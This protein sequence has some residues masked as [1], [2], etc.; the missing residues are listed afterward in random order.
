MN[1]NERAS[2]QFEPV[3]WGV[4]KVEIYPAFNARYYSLYIQGLISLL[5]SSRLEYT[6]RDFPPFGA[7]CLAFR[8]KGDVERKIYLHSNDM[9]ELDEEG[10]RWCDLFG[11]VNLDPELVPE[12]MRSKVLALGP[13]MAVRVWNRYGSYLMA[14]R[15]L[16][17][18]RRILGDSWRQHIAN[19]R[20][21]YSS[22]FP[23]DAY[24]P[25][26]PRPNY[27]FYNAA[28]WEREPK[29]NAV[30]AGFVK[31]CRAMADV[32]FEGGLT[33]RQSV[34]GTG[35]FSAPEYEDFL[36]KR[37]SSRE[38]LERTRL[39]MVTMNNPAYRD[40]HS[41]RLAEYLA[42]G[43][44]IISLPIVRALPSSLDHGV[45]IHYVDGSVDDFRS[46]LRK[47]IG[48]AEYRRTLERNAREYYETYLA[49]TSV[50]ERIL[51][52]AGITGESTS[53]VADEDMAERAGS[54]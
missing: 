52:K 16:L 46:A 17:R 35:R 21:Q 22:R 42:M 34:N 30:R 43:K 9:P 29:A 7:D 50:L 10:L 51:R 37:Y 47:I 39:S 32:R 33:P 8:V 14:F 48:D 4:D 36:C 25:A 44:A 54:A 28:L 2:V 11:K 23:E 49:P 5:G 18:S 53:R 15:N 26:A 1:R 3:E 40:C 20:G 41:W 19:Y 45:H 24:R 38:Y 27:V 31:A 13:T 12:T 6:T